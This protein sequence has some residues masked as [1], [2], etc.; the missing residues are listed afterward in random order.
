VQSFGERIEGLGFAPIKVDDLR[1]HLDVTTSEKIEGGF[2]FK[3]VCTC[4]SLMQMDIS[5]IH[6]QPD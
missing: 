5:D 1:E 4:T 3:N 2:Y 6:R